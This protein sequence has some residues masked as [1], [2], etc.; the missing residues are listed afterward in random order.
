MRSM[1]KSGEDDALVSER[2]WQELARDLKEERPSRMLE[3]LQECGA[4]AR[5]A[6]E[7]AA[8]Y[9]EPERAQA[10]LAA[11]DAAA[12]AGEPLEVRFAALARA[13]DP[14]AVETLANRL[15]MPSSVRELAM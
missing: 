9:E 7:L 3:V 2:V 6:P 11:L 10:A 4:L 8:L 15:K 1:V 5:V 13:L 12:A 14:Y